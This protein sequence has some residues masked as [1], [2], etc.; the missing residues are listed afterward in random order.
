MEFMKPAFV[1]YEPSKWEFI[2]FKANIISIRKR[3]VD[4]EV[5]NDVTSTHHLLLHMW[6]YNFYD[7]MLS[8]DN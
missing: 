2:A 6:S 5:V 7:T 8:A 3:I 4:T 1:S